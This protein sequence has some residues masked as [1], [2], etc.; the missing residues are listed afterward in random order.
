M[1]RA[2]ATVVS[3]VTIVAFADV[4]SGAS[5]DVPVME[6]VQGKPPTKLAG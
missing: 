4:R 6:S 2:I 5:S 1:R 3:G